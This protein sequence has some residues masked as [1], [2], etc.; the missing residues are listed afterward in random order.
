LGAGG[1]RRL[2]GLETDLEEFR[3]RGR[4][5]GKGTQYKPRSRPTIN[6]WWIMIL[7][8]KTPNLALQRV[9]RG[10]IDAKFDRREQ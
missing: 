7:W 5:K 8:Y 4:H 2:I 10:A 9:S 6:Q 3:F 1:V